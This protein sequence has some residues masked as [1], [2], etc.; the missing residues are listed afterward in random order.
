MG[1]LLLLIGLLIL[2]GPL[3]LASAAKNLGHRVGAGNGEYHE[4]LPEN[5]SSALRAALL[6]AGK[7]GNNPIQYHSN[8]KY[9]EFDVQET[10]DGHLVL[11]HD[12][13]LKR[14]L[15]ANSKNK[16]A[17]SSIIK[18][19]RKQ[20]FHPRDLEVDGKIKYKKLGIKDL[21]LEQLKRL[22]LS[23]TLSEKVPTLEEFIFSARELGLVK[24]LVLEIKSIRSDA[25]KWKVIELLASFRDEYFSRTDVVFEKGYDMSPTGVGFLSFPKAFSKSFGK[26]GSKDR[27]GWCKILKDFGFKKIYRAY[28]HSKNL[29]GK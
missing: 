10:R 12:K 6:G 22:V 8:F 23:G 5:S 13:S 18:E 28:F 26:E 19:I 9:L 15:P 1:V 16:K 25:A 14:M 11:F 20:V 3:L 2:P 4:H 7:S 21:S 27:V 24:P 17:I 29:C